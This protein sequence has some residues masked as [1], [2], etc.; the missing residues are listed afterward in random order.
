MMERDIV[1]EYWNA[2]KIAPIVIV[3]TQ[4]QEEALNEAGSN[5]I[6]DEFHPPMEGGVPLNK[7]P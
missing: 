6:P 3:P 7:E 5:S 2:A 4:R 1:Q